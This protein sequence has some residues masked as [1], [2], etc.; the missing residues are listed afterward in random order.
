[1]KLLFYFGHPSQYFFLKETLKRLKKQHHE[2][3]LL[4]KKNVLEDI[5]IKDQLDYI[6]ILPAER[7]LSK[8]TIH[9]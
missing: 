9:V 8:L 7:S 5:L 3:I 6:N 2:V 4:I 1:M